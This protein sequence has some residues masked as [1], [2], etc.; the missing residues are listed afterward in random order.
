MHT[1]AD[2]PQL[3]LCDREAGVGTVV[4]GHDLLHGDQ[5]VLMTALM[6]RFRLT[7]SAQAFEQLFAVAGPIL[8]RRIRHRLR[9]SGCDID[10]ADVLQETLVNVYRYPDHFRCEKDGAFKAWSGAILENA[11]RRLL[12]RRVQHR[13]L[14]EG[15]NDLLDATPGRI[16]ADPAVLASAHE[17]HR[18]LARSWAILLAAYLEVYQTLSVRERQALHL[19][20][21]DRLKYRDVASRLEVR[22]E[23][24][25]MVVFRARKRIVFR[26]TMLLAGRTAPVEI[27]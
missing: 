8:M 1:L 10:E 25:K 14:F 16:D 26:L 3:D 11:I 12:R 22:P 7:R 4:S 27:N 9:R 15:G 21:V 23:A 5:E 18:Q 17:D 24:L 20:E 6:E 13:E 19:V 2:H